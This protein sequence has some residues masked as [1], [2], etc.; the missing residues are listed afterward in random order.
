LRANRVSTPSPRD[1][2]R[3]D[4]ASETYADQNERDYAALHAA[5]KDGT[6]Q[7]TTEI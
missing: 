3:P 6:A 1:S 5:V 2:G 4:V 7:A